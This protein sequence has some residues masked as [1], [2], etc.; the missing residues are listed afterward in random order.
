MGKGN[1]GETGDRREGKRRGEA[2][3]RVWARASQAEI[4]GYVTGDSVTD[5]QTDSIMTAIFNPIQSISQKVASHIHRPTLRRCNS[6]YNDV[7]RYS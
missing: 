1:R 2:G 6:D 7:R 5:R 3:D 4:L